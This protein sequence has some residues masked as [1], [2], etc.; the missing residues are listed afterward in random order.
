M[1]RL[2]RVNKIYRLEGWGEKRV[3]TDVTCTFHRGQS[4]GIL[5][6]NGSG[7]ST[8]LRIL[9]GADQ[10]TQGR[11]YR[12][13]R[14]SWPLAF[15]G[16]HGT[17]TGEENIRFV[18]RIYGVDHRAVVKYVAAFS[19]LG[20]D[21]YE[22]VSSYSTGM[23]AR[24]GFGLSLALEFDFYLIDEVTAVGDARFQKRCREELGSRLNRS[25]VIMVSHNTRGL[26]KYCSHAAILHQGRLSRVMDIKD[27]VPIY[28]KLLGI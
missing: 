25:N 2:D 9:A 21:L 24:L 19:E 10:P 13:S 27:A 17:L 14:V 15:G 23:R 8:L 4:V 20:N 3:L 16:F 11:V 12:H 7:K 18:S 5:G 22:P 1:I 26:K 28:N 6:L